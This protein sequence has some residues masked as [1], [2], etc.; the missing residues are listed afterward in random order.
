MG[1]GRDDFGLALSGVRALARGPMDDGG[2]A[3]REIGLALVVMGALA[4][5]S[6]TVRDQAVTGCRQAGYLSATAD[7]GHW[8]CYKG[9]PLAW[10][11]PL[12]TT[13]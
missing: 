4:A 1:Y 12:A 11:A 10:P 8:Y 6:T 5:C 13:P 7:A 2:P 3:M 9:P